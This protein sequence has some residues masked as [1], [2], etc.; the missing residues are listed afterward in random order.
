MLNDAVVKDWIKENKDVLKD[1]EVRMG[2]KFFKRMG[3]TS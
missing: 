1:G 3:V 2:I